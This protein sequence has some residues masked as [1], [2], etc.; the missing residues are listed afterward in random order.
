LEFRNA[1]QQILMAWTTKG[2]T[3]ELAD[4]DAQKIYDRD[5][6][7][8]KEKVISEAPIYLVRRLL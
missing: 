1:T 2:E 3:N 4:F 5:G 7:N 6:N 8:S